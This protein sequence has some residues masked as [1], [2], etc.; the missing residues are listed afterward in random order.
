MLGQQLDK[1]SAA[2]AQIENALP[3]K[4]VFQVHGLAQFDVGR[5]ASEL[6]FEGEI[7]ER[8]LM[9]ALVGPVCRL[10]GTVPFDDGSLLGNRLPG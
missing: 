6:V 1:L 8:L 10:G 4:K 2:A 7:V 9:R 5:R 3:P